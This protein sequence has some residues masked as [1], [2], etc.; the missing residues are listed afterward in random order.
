MSSRNGGSIGLDNP[1]E[2]AFLGPAYGRGEQLVDRCIHYLGIS[3]GAIGSVALI[4]AAAHQHDG[5]LFASIILYAASLLFM[6]AA[7]A[8]YNFAVPSRRRSGCVAST[9]PRSS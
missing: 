3:A 6:I 7:S 8:L 4:V 9:T 2:A 1:T 5:W